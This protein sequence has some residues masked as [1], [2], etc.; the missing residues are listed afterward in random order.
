MIILIYSLYESRIMTAKRKTFVI[1]DV[2]SNV[3]RKNSLI[4]A[5]HILI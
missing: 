2:I 1:T 4:A 3:I 5:Q